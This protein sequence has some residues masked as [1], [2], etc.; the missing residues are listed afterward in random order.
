MR[1]LIFVEMCRLLKTM[2]MI[3]HVCARRLICDLGRLVV[4]YDTDPWYMICGQVEGEVSEIYCVVCV[5]IR[6]EYVKDGDVVC[7]L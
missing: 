7:C 2:V 1:T 4:I 3:L 5:F 6:M